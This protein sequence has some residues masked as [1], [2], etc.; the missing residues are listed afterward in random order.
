MKRI[1]KP[2]KNSECSEQYEREKIIREVA[3]TL[4]KTGREVIPFYKQQIAHGY[5]GYVEL[6]KLLKLEDHT[7][8]QYIK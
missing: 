3:K 4:G 1:D 5:N 8:I 2:L 7:A 6:V